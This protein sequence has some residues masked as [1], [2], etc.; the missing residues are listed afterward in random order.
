MAKV[1]NQNSVKSVHISNWK[2]I[3]YSRYLNI[4]DLTLGLSI[5]AINYGR[6]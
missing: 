1:L 4:K 2:R 3:R 6:I 5:T